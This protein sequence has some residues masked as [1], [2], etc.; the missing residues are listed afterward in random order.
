MSI[1]SGW[2]TRL[3]CEQ[4]EARETPTVVAG[5]NESVFATGLM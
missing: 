5:F 4:L 3:R 1:R 2:F